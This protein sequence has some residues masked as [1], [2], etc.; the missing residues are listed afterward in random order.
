MKTVRDDHNATAIPYLIEREHEREQIRARDGIADENAIEFR[1]FNLFERLCRG[2]SVM[3]DGSDAG[4]MQ[5]TAYRDPIHNVVVDHENTRSPR[6]AGVVAV[7]T[8][9]HPYARVSR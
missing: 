1:A 9:I 7:F 5:R 2:S 4:L 3:D 6:L 8:V